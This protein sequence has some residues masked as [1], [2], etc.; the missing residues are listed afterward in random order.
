MSSSRP[1]RI[2][3]L[4]PGSVAV[5]RHYASLVSELAERGH[6]VRLAFPKPPSDRL[7]R[8]LAEIPRR[9]P[10][11]V[12]DVVPG[13]R[14]LDGWRSVAWLVRGLADLARY[15]H[16][17]YE[18]A[19]A[20][21][22][23]ITGQ[24]FDRLAQPWKFEPVGRRLALRLAR[25]L[26]AATDAELSERVIRRAARMEASIPTCRAID[27]YIRERAP[28]IVLVTPVVR[29]GSP[30]VE[31]LKSARRLGVPTGVCVAS[32][33][34]LTNKG[35]LR[36]VPERVFVWNEVQRREAV[37]LHGVPGERVVATGGQVF[38][39][40]FERRPSRS[41]EEFVRSVGLDP[42]EPYVLYV[43]SSPFVT[44]HSQ[45][46]VTLVTRW[47]EA[48]R[49]SADD[50]LR[51]LGVM[52]RPHP[53]GKVWRDVDLSGLGNAVVWP[54]KSRRP[55]EAQDRADFFDSFVHS[56]A[57]V[58]INTTAMIEGAI[59]GKSVLSV[60]AP[61]FAQESTLHFHY[62]LEENGGFLSVAS[63]LDELC[64]RLVGVLDQGAADAER[65]RRFVESFVRPH[66]LDRP[67]TPIFAD[68]VE[69]LAALTPDRPVRLSLLRFPLALEAGLCS[70]TM[71][72]AP[73]RR[74]FARLRRRMVGK[75]QRH[76][77]V[78][79]RSVG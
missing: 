1:L 6:D 3:F 44:A 38:D 61:E 75:A 17:R 19:P 47:I 32:W 63:S 4:L 73:A 53:V 35:L 25:R 23:R 16:P 13:R 43:C 64:E 52:V 21:R 28:E 65:R 62:L 46:E 31:Y 14:A 22:R 15:S 42:A 66:G 77:L 18:P 50:P 39:E 33:D 74:R 2:L 9:S 29:L 11:A 41:R 27:R 8:L 59:V 5:V 58:G 71:R 24:V 7:S 57:V 68:A 34:N 49:A 67:A 51:R 79:R 36:F 45:N 72:S 20:L 26:S 54:I 55:V 12:H 56:A 10:P 60:L 78:P 76:G 70:L 69:E 37:E 40:W 30:Q 48:L